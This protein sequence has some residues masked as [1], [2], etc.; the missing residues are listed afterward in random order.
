[1]RDYVLT[2]VRIG[3]IQSGDNIGQ[4]YINASAKSINPKTGRREIGIK[5]FNVQIWEEDDK[6]IIDRVRATFPKYGGENVNGHLLPWN[7]TADIDPQNFDVLNNQEELSKWLIFNNCMTKLE[8]LG[9]FYCMKYMSDFNGHQAGDWVCR[10]DGYVQ[11]W[12]E[13]LILV[14]KDENGEYLPGWDPQ[15]RLHR[16]LRFMYSLSRV[17]QENPDLVDQYTMNR[18]LLNK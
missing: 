15:T 2:N 5:G 16:E 3:K 12:E 6:D 4:Y 17:I 8:P 13:R 10:R 18:Y 1:M 9:D 14:R 11:V 7:G